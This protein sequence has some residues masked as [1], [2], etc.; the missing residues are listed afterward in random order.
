MNR[1]HLLPF[2]GVTDNSGTVSY[3]SGC[4]NHLPTRDSCHGGR[5]SRKRNAT[6]GARELALEL[7]NTLVKP[8]QSPLFDNPKDY[9]L[10]HQDVTFDT[11]DGVT[12]SEWLIKGAAD[13]VIIQSYFGVQCCRS[14][15]EGIHQ[16]IADLFSVFT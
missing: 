8:C 9:G 7:A 14:G 11:S 10:D 4:R 16:G 15:G 1:P 6:E 5:V 2:G 13:K 3:G 12:L